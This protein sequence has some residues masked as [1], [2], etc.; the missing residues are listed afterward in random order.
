MKHIQ[1]VVVGDYVLCVNNNMEI[2]FND[3]IEISYCEDSFQ[4]VIKLDNGI[5]IS[6]T[7]DMEYAICE[8]DNSIYVF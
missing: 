7:I 8:M 4:F 6:N 1:E 5:Y 3:V 2:S